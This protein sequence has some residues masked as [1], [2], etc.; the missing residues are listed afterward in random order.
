VVVG[1]VRRFD[2]SELASDE[3]LSL[4]PAEAFD[5]T[6]TRR[7]QT[8]RKAV[9]GA[10]DLG[11]ERPAVRASYGRSLFGQ[12]C[13][14]ARRLVERGVP[15]VEVTLPGWDT[16]QDNAATVQRLSADLDA[17]WAS[18]L[19]DL[20]ERGR[21]QTTLVVWMGEFGRTP[22]VNASGGRDHWP[23]CF[24]VALAGCGIKGGQVIGKTSA[25]GTRIE[26]Y[27]IK[28]PELLATIYQA[29]GIN[30]RMQYLSNTGHPVRL[31]EPVAHP[32]RE[33]LR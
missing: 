15:V 23:R 3:L 4:P 17:A 2:G 5:S 25:D 31:A 30:P 1:E 12:G 9:A 27:P 18:L 24:S 19:R 14:L 16:H 26:E 6:A 28:P 22:R 33:V 10:F 20:H 8:L 29:L 32:V 13:L 11:A 7:A 21:L